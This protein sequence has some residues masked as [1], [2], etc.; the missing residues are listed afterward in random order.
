MVSLKLFKDSDILL[1]DSDVCFWQ[2]EY[3]LGDV[4]HLERIDMYGYTDFKAIKDQP[5]GY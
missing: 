3:C 1:L 5:E 4:V 2:F